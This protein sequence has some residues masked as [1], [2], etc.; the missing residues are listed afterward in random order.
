MLKITIARYQRLIICTEARDFMPEVT[1]SL[2]ACS[3]IW[4]DSVPVCYFW[5]CAILT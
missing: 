4:H 5:N 2:I 3:T 1:L